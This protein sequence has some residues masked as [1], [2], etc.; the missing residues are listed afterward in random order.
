[1]VKVRL[2]SLGHFHPPTVLD[3][4][5]FDELDIGSSS[6]WIASAT[7]IL[8]RRSVLTRDMIRALRRG[9]VSSLELRRS[10]AVMTVAGMLRPAWEMACARAGVALPQVDQ[11]IAGTSVPDY[12]I[13]ANACAVAGE[14]GLAAPE[15]AFDANS[16]CSSFVLALHLARQ[17]LQARSAPG[18]A[19]LAIFHPERYTTRVDY[20]DRASCILWGDGATAGWV[21]SGDEGPPGGFEIVDTWMESNPEKYALVQIPEG[22]TFWQNGR[23]VQKFAITKTVAAAKV[24]LERHGLRADDLAYFIGHQANLRMLQS[25]A[26]ALGLGPEQHLFNVDCFGNQGAAGVSATLSAA[27]DRIKPGD[28]V[29]LAVVGAGLTWG[30]A[31][32]RRV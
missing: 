15:G 13:P 27:W 30:A 18:G 12:D 16:A 7:G 22:G 1:M 3:N 5:F 4:A 10:G 20:A 26:S 19:T 31:L 6:D 2:V 25:A 32:L 17:L 8:S 21:T 29:L 23:A 11:V 28:S 9:E 24:L 14:L